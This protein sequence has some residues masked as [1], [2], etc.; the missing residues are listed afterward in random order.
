[1]IGHRAGTTE[2]VAPEGLAGQLRD[3]TV[4]IKVRVDAKRMQVISCTRVAK[5][6]T[7]LTA[8]VTPA[9]TMTSAATPSEGMTCTKRFL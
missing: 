1:L 4:L 8:Y 5:N 2:E 9:V 3:A 6:A 7:Y